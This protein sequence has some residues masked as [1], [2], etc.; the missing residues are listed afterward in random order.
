MS[1]RSRVESFTGRLT[2][3][4]QRLV[5]AVLADPTAAAFLSADQLGDR[6]GVHGATVVRLAQKLGFDGYAEMRTEL[7]EAVRERAG[8]AERIDRVLRHSTATGLLGQLVAAE[9]TNLEALPEQID[10]GAL[11]QAAELMARASRVLV[12]AHGHATALA[13]L[14]ERR[15]RRSGLSVGGLL[16]GGREMAEH[17]VSLSDQDV[18]FGFALRIPPPG[19]TALLETATE[20]NAAVILVS[21]LLGP[22][23]RP[24]PTVLLSASRGDEAEFQS[25][26][27]PMAIVNALVLTMAQIDQGRSMAALERAD[28]LIARFGGRGGET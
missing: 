22:V 10:S 1:F 20:T 6:A 25:L 3:S 16:G 12:Y 4:D 26:T 28:A 8:A 21:D 27:V 9:I 2:E 18:V 15:L 19:L 14:T 7:G 13:D 5:A 17:L 24:R 11:E 23:I